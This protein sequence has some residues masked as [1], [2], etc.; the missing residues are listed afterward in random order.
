MLC[1]CAQ[2]PAF[3]LFSGIRTEVPM[4]AIRGN[5]VGGSHTSFFSV[6]RTNT[7]AVGRQH[8]EPASR[9]ANKSRFR[10]QSWVPYIRSVSLDSEIESKFTMSVPLRSKGFWKPTTRSNQLG[11]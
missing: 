6:E 1:L 9:H 11:S 4:L 10:R 7:G 8:N 3:K 2:M 5:S